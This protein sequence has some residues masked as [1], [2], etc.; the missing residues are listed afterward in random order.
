M[1]YFQA[2]QHGVVKVAYARVMLIG[3]G[4]VGISSLLSGLRKKKFSKSTDSTQGADILNLRP[5]ESYWA[6]ITGGHWEIITDED[7]IKELAQLVQRVQQNEQLVKG[8]HSKSSSEGE[9]SFVVKEDEKFNHPSIKAIVDE[10]MAAYSEP[11]YQNSS[12]PDTEVYLRVWDC[13]G[14]P[15]FLNLLSAFLTARTLFLLMFDASLDL[16]G[17]CLHLTHHEGRATEQLDDMST[18]QLMV[19]WM[20]NIHATL[21]EKGSVGSSSDD[22]KVFP[23]ILPVGTHGDKAYAK[24]NKD[25]ILRTLA[26]ESRNK[27][28]SSH[29]L[30]G[31]V[32][33][34]TTAGAGESEDPVF[35]I[36]REIAN[37]FAEKDLAIDTPITWVLFRKVFDRYLR[38]KPVVDIDEV[39]ELAEACFIPENTIPSVLGFYHDLSVFFHYSSVPSLKCKVISDPRWLI[40]QMAKILALEGFEEVRS[41]ALWNLLREDGILVET[42]YNQVLSNQGELKPQDIIDLLEHFLIIAN[43]RTSNKHKFPG[44]EYFVPSMLPC[45]SN[46]NL[47]PAIETIQSAAPI[48]LIFS[49]NYLPPG[50]FTRLITVLSKYENMTVDF[51]EKLYRNAVKF[52]YG[53]CQ[54]DKVITTEEKSSVSVEVHRILTRPQKT[55]FIPCYLPGT[56]ADS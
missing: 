50:F 15:V 51:K 28:F 3:P 7:E 14:Q 49:T 38:G 30:D 34:N 43:V 35:Q 44:R 27:A 39:K 1:D 10:I 20:A 19:Q 4:G 36:I 23:R 6:R 11:G 2:L 52:R 12:Q 41:N 25:A 13:G 16:H 46:K 40:K 26:E 17:P 55:H 56:S 48:H 31:A 47:Q 37:K 9:P 29:L 53:H 18:L 54:I 22:G 42:L 45:I 21:L 8:S 33:D 32:V 24:E 5:T